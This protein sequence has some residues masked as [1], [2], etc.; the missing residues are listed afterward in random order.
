MVGCCACGCAAACAG[1]AAS[2]AACGCAAAACCHGGYSSY[3]D[4][5][6]ETPA[7]KAKRIAN[8][9]KEKARVAAEKK[10]IIEECEKFNAKNVVYNNYTISLHY[11]TEDERYKGHYGFNNMLYE[12]KKKGESKE[13]LYHS[14]RE[15]EQMIDKFEAEGTL[16]KDIDRVFHST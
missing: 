13:F 5:D 2:A 6:D 16:H 12:A 11:A 1:C 4:D 10:K 8:E 7:Q 15:T 14:L 9:K 3:D